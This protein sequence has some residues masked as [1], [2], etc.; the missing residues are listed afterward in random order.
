MDHCGHHF[1]HSFVSHAGDSVLLTTIANSDIPL[2]DGHEDLMTR[3]EA[4]FAVAN[5]IQKEK[6]R[7][8]HELDHMI[9]P[10]LRRQV[11]WV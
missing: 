4:M 8:G 9:V 10:A 7:Q 3:I 2:D 5:E 6:R 1:V 11:F